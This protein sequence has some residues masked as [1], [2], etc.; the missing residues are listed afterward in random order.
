M[1]NYCMETLMKEVPKRART[2]S[3]GAEL[4]GD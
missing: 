3:G 1:A 2:I 4:G